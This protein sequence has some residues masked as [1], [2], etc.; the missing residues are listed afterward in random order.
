MP[1]K[2]NTD[3]KLSQELVLLLEWL[4]CNEQENMIKL[5]YKALKKGLRQQISTLHKQKIESH[6]IDPTENIIQFLS[7]VDILL[8]DSLSSLMKNYNKSTL[9]VF[10]QHI[11]NHTKNADILAQSIEIASKKA[12]ENPTI[13]PK[14]AL[15]MEFIKKWKPL[16]EKIH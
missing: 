11:E 16:D 10:A 14:D 9:H 12:N 1:Y 2:K 5:I 8:H 15:M 7:I 13:N 3:I 4:V 6:S